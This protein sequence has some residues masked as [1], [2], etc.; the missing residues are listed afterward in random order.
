MVRGDR[1][2]LATE[3]FRKSEPEATGFEITLAALIA[4]AL[5]TFPLAGRNWLSN[6]LAFILLVTTLVRRISVASPFADR[7][8]IDVWSTPIIEAATTISLLSLFVYF[9]NPI[10]EY[11]EYSH[12]LVFTVG[13]LFTVFT[14]SFIHEFLFRDYLIWWNAKFGQKADQNDPPTWLWKELALISYFSSMARRNREGF[15]NIPSNTKPDLDDLDLNRSNVARFLV[16]TVIVLLLF[17]ILPGFVSLFFFG[18]AGILLAPAVVFV[19]D[20]ACFWYIA[21]GSTSYEDL[22]KPWWAVILWS[23]GYVAF[24]ALVI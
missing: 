21:Y 17:L 20:F 10:A 12:L 11:I 13:A 3:F 15:R 2:E 19:H 14:L 9:S 4:T 18:W 7:E 5:I 6:A 24:V 8:T 23:T 22:R 1:R 16:T